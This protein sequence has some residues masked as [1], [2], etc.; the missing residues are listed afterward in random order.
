MTPKMSTGR[1]PR[2]DKSFQTRATTGQ[3][4]KIGFVMWFRGILLVAVTSTTSVNTGIS[5][6]GYPRTRYC[7]TGPGKPPKCCRCHSAPKPKK[8]QHPFW[9]IAQKLQYVKEHTKIV[10]GSNSQVQNP[11]S[12]A[13]TAT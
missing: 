4:S 10:L 13:M 3:V 8:E 7:S 12:R 5:D 2:D 1:V 11:K 6:L 9:T